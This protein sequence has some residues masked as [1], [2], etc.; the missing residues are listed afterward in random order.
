MRPK[1]HQRQSRRVPALAAV[2]AVVV[3]V[4]DMRESGG[5]KLGEL[6]SPTLAG[7][8]CGYPR[9]NSYSSEHAKVLYRG[10]ASK[11]E[12]S[13]R[14]AQLSVAG[15]IPSIENEHDERKA[16]GAIRA[17]GS[18]RRRRSGFSRGTAVRACG[19]LR[20]R[21]GRAL[22]REV[23]IPAIAPHLSLPS[24]DAGV[25]IYLASW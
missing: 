4:I 2:R 22:P 8:A 12:K 9:D 18:C 6:H 21:E 20:A 11:N 7:T 10:A 24:S 5:F 17:G 3:A 23:G 25:L 14:A 19:R 1:L 15:S 16:H 13:R